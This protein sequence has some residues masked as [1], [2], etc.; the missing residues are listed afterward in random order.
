VGLPTEK[1]DQIFNA[2]FTTKPQ[3]HRPASSGSRCLVSAAAGGD[4]RGDALPHGA[5]E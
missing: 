1:V 3:G 4:H 5:A 2:F